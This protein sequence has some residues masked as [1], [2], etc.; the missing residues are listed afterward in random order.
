MTTR[1]FERVREQISLRPGAGAAAILF[2][3]VI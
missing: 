2:L 3:A 1:M